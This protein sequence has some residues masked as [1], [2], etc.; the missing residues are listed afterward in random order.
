M[1]FF[2]SLLLRR[3]RDFGQKIVPPRRDEIAGG[4]G[5]S[6]ADSFPQKRVTV[7]YINR[8][9]QQDFTYLNAHIHSM[10]LIHTN[11]VFFSKVKVTSKC[12][13]TACSGK[14]VFTSNTCQK[15]RR[16]AF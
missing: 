13:F 8:V 1:R 11:V 4:G 5:E 2:S 12:Q 16:T 3:R 9:A 7:D 15:G 10:T 6:R 14:K